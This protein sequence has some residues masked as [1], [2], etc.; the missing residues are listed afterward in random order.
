[1]EIQMILR[2]IGEHAHIV[3]H[4]V[5]PVQIQRVR[6]R[7]HHHMGAPGV[8]HFPEQL[9]DLKGFRR[10]TVRWK[11]RVADHILVGADKTHLGPCRLL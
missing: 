10:G 6:R 5:D 1:M 11:R 3:V 7:L 8:R 2:Q 9:L 4:A